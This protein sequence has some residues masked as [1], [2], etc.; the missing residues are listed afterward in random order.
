MLPDA[1]DVVLTMFFEEVR[2]QFDLSP[3]DDSV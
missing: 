3:N 1:T 2:V